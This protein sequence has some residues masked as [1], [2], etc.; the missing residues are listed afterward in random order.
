[1]IAN[2]QSALS[3]DIAEATADVR[4]ATGELTELSKAVHAI[5]LKSDGLAD[6]RLM[7]RDSASRY[8]TLRAKCTDVVDV[9]DLQRQIS[10]TR[11]DIVEIEKEI[12][13]LT[14][15]SIVAERIE[16]A[17]EERLTLLAED[18]ELIEQLNALTIELRFLQNSRV[19]DESISGSTFE[20]LNPEAIDRPLPMKKSRTTEGRPLA[21]TVS[22]HNL[23]EAFHLTRAIR[24]A[25]A[26]LA[27]QL[28]RESDIRPMIVDERKKER[29]IQELDA[30]ITKETATG[31]AM[32][33]RNSDTGSTIEKVTE[34]IER[35]R[36]AGMRDVDGLKRERNVEE[37]KL[38]DL[39]ARL[40]EAK[41]E[42]EQ[43]ADDEPAVQRRAIHD[44]ARDLQDE[45]VGLE[46]QKTRLAQKAEA[47]ESVAAVARVHERV[48]A[49]KEIP[50][51]E[52]EIHETELKQAIV[53]RQQRKLTRAIQQSQ[54]ILANFGVVPPP[55]G[56]GRQTL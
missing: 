19:T 56:G 4:A 41:A 27:D 28:R 31:A 50:K 30:D 10:R 18:N 35:F 38:R 48:E 32:G 13:E 6:E 45:I 40:R 55:F 14:D 37:R 7:L 34:V 24:R 36:R 51:I 8:E 1:M 47:C 52:D 9:S 29:L 21:K 53:R 54:A 3:T 43:L 46:W 16:R 49:E 22:N 39:R 42:L 23:V 44:A 11:A 2:E 25:R 17:R 15:G 26:G 33:E 5:R 20:G 12:L